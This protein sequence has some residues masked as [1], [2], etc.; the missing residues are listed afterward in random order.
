MTKAQKLAEKNPQFADAKKLMI[1][2]GGRY[3]WDASRPGG[4]IQ[5]EVWQLGLDIYHVTSFG[6][7]GADIYEAI[8]AG[9]W[10]D[11]GAHLDAKLEAEKAGQ[12]KALGSNFLPSDRS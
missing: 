7:E 2:R 1:D 8:Q 5:I 3:L 10:A 4:A 12:R 9:T 6:S 11:I